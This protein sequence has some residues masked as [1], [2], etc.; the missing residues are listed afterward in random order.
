MSGVA[1]RT[2]TLIATLG[3]WNGSGNAYAYQWQRSGDGGNT[4][5]DVA[6]ATG[7]TYTLGQADEGMNLR[8]LVTATNPDGT[9]SAASPA[10]ARC[11]PPRR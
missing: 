7:P 10:T 4:W 3:S 2:A 1:Q 8:V 5:T 11:R 6:G 9:A